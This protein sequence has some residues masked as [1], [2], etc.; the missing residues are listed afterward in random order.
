M[1]K[2]TNVNPNEDYD[3][4]NDTFSDNLFDNPIPPEEMEGLMD[5]LE[6]LYKE[7]S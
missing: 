7:N 3:F 4:S 5:Y 1:K 2:N 6:D